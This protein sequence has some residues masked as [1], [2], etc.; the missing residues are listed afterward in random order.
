VLPAQTYPG[1][2]VA[3][4]SIGGRALLATT[5]HL[6]DE[7]ARIVIDAV[8]QGLDQLR[9]V[10]PALRDLD[11]AALAAQPQAVPLHDAAVAYFKLPR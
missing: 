3:L 11:P 1:Q 6:G 8:M 4:P 2:A 9:L 5:S 10:H 7:T